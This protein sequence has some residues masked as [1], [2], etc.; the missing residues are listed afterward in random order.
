MCPT[1]RK[2][3]TGHHLGLTRRLEIRSGGPN[4]VVSIRSMP[5]GRSGYSK[6]VRESAPNRSSVQAF[7]GLGFEAETRVQ[8]LAHDH[9]LDLRRLNQQAP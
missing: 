9:V 3:C 5:S 4:S 8:V 2:S 1:V 7:I 6:R